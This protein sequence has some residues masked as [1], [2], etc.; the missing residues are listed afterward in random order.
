MNKA[1]TGDGQ[2]P[3]YIACFRGHAE[4]VS[5]LLAQDGIEVN[6]A[7]TVGVNIESPL[8]ITCSRGHLV[9]VQLLMLRGAD[10][11][12]PSMASVR[13]AAQSHPAIDGWL[14]AA[15]SWS[16]LRIAA[17]CRFHKEA[18]L[19]LRQGRLDPEAELVSE[20]WPVLGLQSR[21]P[22]RVLSE[23]L[24][25][26]G[27]SQTKRCRSALQRSRLFTTQPTD[28]PTRCTGFTTP[29]QGVLLVA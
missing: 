17:S 12:P 13:T 22:R 5:L 18:A 14:A 16:Q 28:G 6:K 10:V 26:I 20:I 11:S 9:L 7:R 8:Y 3:L 29:T 4:V 27:A 15:A 23:I 1:R 19:M 25:A 24:E 2:T 21:P